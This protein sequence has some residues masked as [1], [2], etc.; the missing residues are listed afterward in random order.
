[1]LISLVFAIKRGLKFHDL[2]SV[3]DL[4]LVDANGLSAYACAAATLNPTLCLQLE[5]LAVNAAL[6]SSSK[7]HH[8]SFGQIRRALNTFHRLDSLR[9]EILFAPADDQPH[10]G[11]C[12]FWGDYLEHG[13]PEH[14]NL[15][16]DGYW[17][18]CSEWQEQAIQDDSLEF[19]C[20]ASILPPPAA[21]TVQWFRLRKR[22]SFEESFLSEAVSLISTAENEYYDTE[23]VVTD[24]VINN[25]KQAFTLLMTGIRTCEDA[26]LKSQAADYLQLAMQRL[27]SIAPDQCTFA[28]SSLNL[29]TLASVNAST[30][31]LPAV[32]KTFPLQRLASKIFS[33]KTKKPTSPSA[34]TQDD[35]KFC[36]VCSRKL[37]ESEDSRVEHLNA[38]LTQST[39]SIR[40]D[41]YTV[42]VLSSRD[43]RECPICCEE[44][45]GAGG[46]E[47][48]RIAVMN[49][50][51]RFHE[52]CIE[53][54]FTRSPTCPFHSD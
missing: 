32:T 49:C 38:C 21:C 28:G 9:L 5:C 3:S 4:A 51:C 10:A 1:M 34:K 13:G 30:A 12:D 33:S 45:V 2:A 16:V 8:F 11:W 25:F 7:S 36:P 14:V 20:K 52:R 31:S 54:W 15:P 40:G 43:P 35:L 50:L 6:A 53:R 42:H 37:A 19:N 17:Q 22:K 44:F 24:G 39:S 29:P 47:S 18:W 46:C 48:E 23:M 26:Q 41:R 27:D